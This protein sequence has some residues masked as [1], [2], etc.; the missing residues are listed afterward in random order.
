MPERRRVIRRSEGH[1]KRRIRVSLSRTLNTGNYESLKVE[2]EYGAM[3]EDRA[4][5]EEEYAKCVELVIKEIQKVA[6]DVLDAIGTNN[7]R[8]RRTGVI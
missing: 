1:K 2:A 3:I 7:S 5:T 4:D 6:T 8:R